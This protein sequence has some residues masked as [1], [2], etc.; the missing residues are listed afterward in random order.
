MPH[1]KISLRGMLGFTFGV[2][3]L[4]LTIMI[5]P[6]GRVAADGIDTI[7]DE[8]VSQPL[9]LD[10]A[11]SVESEVVAAKDLPQ[12]VAGS[13]GPGEVTAPSAILMDVLTGQVLFEKNADE[14]RPPASITKLMTIFLVY[15]AVNNGNA[16]MDDVVV[17][18]ERAQSM[19]GTQAFLAAG[20]TFTLADLVKAIIVASANDASVAV[21]EHL[22]GSVEAFA[23]LMNR[24][25][26]ELGMRNS[27]FRNPHG[28]D[29]PEH[30]MSARDVAIVSRELLRKYPEVLE[31]SS[32]WTYTFQVAENCCL[33][34]N[35]NRMVRQYR[36]VDGLK[37]GW[38]SRA[39]YSVSAT[40]AR[41][42]TRLVAVVMGH[43]NPNV[44]FEEAAR[45]LSWGFAGWESLFI[46]AGG[47]VLREI[48]V[49][50]GNQQRLGLIAAQ[51]F[52]VLLNK[53]KANA[54][55]QVLEA[56]Q[57]IVAPVK[58]GDVLGA[59]VVKDGDEELGRVDLLADRSVERLSIFSLWWRLWQGLQQEV[60]GGT[61]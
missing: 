7:L 37:T 36:G 50:E 27:H 24:K 4:L 21:A 58:R 43:D 44:R 5:I 56:P 48:P 2:F 55:S 53:T 20:Q 61:L 40:G 18:S 32:V 57:H 31:H 6:A 34:T 23:E 54:V 51:D 46:V 52:G 19:G 29:D 41:G 3:L 13:A 39:G 30:V 38:T 28:L 12:P 33:L 45:L 35:T 14:P 49:Y 47:D 16:S 25:A 17:I 11:P 26:E 59:L 9:P 60:T 42:D 22:A 8:D 10:Q 1:S 15:E